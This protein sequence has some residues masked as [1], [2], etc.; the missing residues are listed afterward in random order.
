MRKLKNTPLRTYYSWLMIALSYWVFM[1]WKIS[2]QFFGELKNSY[3]IYIS[4]IFVL[5]FSYIP[6]V[7]K[8]IE[9]PSW[10]TGVVFTMAIALGVPFVLESDHIRY[11]WDGLNG[12]NGINPYAFAPKNLEQFYEVSWAKYINHP[13]LP[14]IYPPLAQVLFHISSYLN[15]Y[16][17]PFLLGGAGLDEFVPTHTWQIYIGWKVLVGVLASLMIYIIR[18]FDW[19]LIIFNPLFLL[20]GLANSHLD[21]VVCILLI[22]FLK[23]VLDT[24]KP[25]LYFSLILSMVLI[26]WYPLIF[27]PF[28]FIYGHRKYGFTKNVYS[29]LMIAVA[30]GLLCFSYYSSSGGNF[31]S[32][33]MHFSK[34]WYFFGFLH[35]FLAD[36]LSTFMDNS[37]GVD[38]A[39]IAVSFLGLI[40][41][42]TLFYFYCKNK[43][44]IKASILLMSTGLL[45][46]S[47]TLHPWYLL[48]L[49]AG[50]FPFISK[51]NF[52]WVWSILSLLSIIYYIIGSDPYVLRY[53]VYSFIILIMCLDL[54]KSMGYSKRSYL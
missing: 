17:W 45:V 7:F 32:S 5:G 41:A 31:L 8:S 21:V 30:A 49:L 11:I 52:I 24:K 19:H 33:A 51:I 29:F 37:I 46:C 1:S 43:L 16:F 36:F 6:V 9:K 2:D 48:L 25:L 38:K 3:F 54:R 40:Y 15:P 22:I 10:K 18:D 14:T 20:K 12:A 34:H 13:H 44:S 26:K 39:R 42:A 28:L 23:K 27:F 35:R 53:L 50:G 47:P 4:F